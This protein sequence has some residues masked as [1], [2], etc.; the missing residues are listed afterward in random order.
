MIAMKNAADDSGGIY[1]QH[2]QIFQLCKD[3]VH[4]FATHLYFAHYHTCSNV[5][6][7][8]LAFCIHLIGGNAGIFSIFL[9]VRE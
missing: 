7:V 1:I 8:T 6:L 9:T 2:I 5:D 4:I 3:Y